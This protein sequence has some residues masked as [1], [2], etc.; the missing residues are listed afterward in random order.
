MSEV[1]QAHPSRAQLLVV[2]VQE[3][4]MPHIDGAE[5]VIAQTV[6]MIRAA[7]EVRLPVTLSEQNA[8][9]LGGTVAQ[10][11]EAAGDA[12]RI[13]KMH[14]SVC[15][16]KEARTRL[17]ALMRP[18]VL[19]CGVEAHVCV[20]QT[21]LDLLG[22]QM[23]PIVLADA[24]SSRRPLDREVALARM[25][26]AGVVVTTVESVIFELL[27]RCDTDLFRRVLPLVK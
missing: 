7:R 14:F 21:A 4:L 23:E 17:S 25:R 12:P 15:G 11:A 26:A 1:I 18:Q 16:S 27:E 10:I 24:V 20:Q 8:R 9:S 3:R 22:D 6:R 5:A 19:L 13:A 2:D